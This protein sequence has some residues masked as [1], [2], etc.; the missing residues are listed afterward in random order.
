MTY[1]HQLLSNKPGMYN[2]VS[3]LFK[4]SKEFLHCNI[5]RSKFLPTFL[6]PYNALFTDQHLIFNN[7][8]VEKDPA[9]ALN[10][11]LKSYQLFKTIYTDGSKSSHGCGFGIFINDSPTSISEKI[12]PSSSIFTAETSAISFALDIIIKKKWEKALI[13]TD[14]LSAIISLFQNGLDSTMHPYIAEIKGKIYRLRQVGSDIKIMWIPG[15][16]NIHGNEQA[17]SLAKKS[18]NIPSNAD[19]VHIVVQDIFPSFKEKMNKDSA[20]SYKNYFG[21]NKK[22]KGE[23]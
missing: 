14:S 2:K 6:I 15:H 20:F 23:K 11:I 17:D 7:L 19:D 18:C 13:L 4:V 12:H 9:K 3:F 8:N 5:Y 1:L 16:K 21:P 10:Q 22:L